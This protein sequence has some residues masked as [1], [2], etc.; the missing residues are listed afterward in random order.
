METKDETMNAKKNLM[1]DII[2]GVR[3]KDNVP[4][5]KV[6][7]RVAS[8]GGMSDVEGHGGLW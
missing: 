8:A 3:A 4:V 7:R 5:L 6:Q 1:R 2:R